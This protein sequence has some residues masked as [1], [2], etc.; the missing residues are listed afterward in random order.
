[1]KGFR[2]YEEFADKRKGASE[3]NVV[4]VLVANGLS[5]TGLYDAIAGVD[6]RPNSP[7]AGTGVQP[8]YLRKRCKRVSE[9]RAREIHRQLFAYLSQG[10]P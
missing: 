9:S 7:V 8:L 1:V 2:F 6:E 4:A 10:E 3:G 5:S